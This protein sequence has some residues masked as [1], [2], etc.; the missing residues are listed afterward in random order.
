MKKLTKI[1]ICL[2]LC[3]F[4][5]GFVACDKR[6]EREKNF[7]YPAAADPI[8]GNGGMA[9]KK[10]NYLYFVNGYQSISNNDILCFVGNTTCWIVDRSTN[11]KIKNFY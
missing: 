5:I 1:L 11:K 4:S 8:V 3:V 6:T 9:V 10:G 2:M 7:T